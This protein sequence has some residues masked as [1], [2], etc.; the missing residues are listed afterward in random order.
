MCC[1]FVFGGID[2]SEKDGLTIHLSEI[3]EPTLP[4]LVHEILV[5]FYFFSSSSSP[6]TRLERE[7]AAAAGHAALSA[8]HPP[9]EALGQVALRPIA[10]A[11][12]HR[13]LLLPLHSLRADR[14]RHRGRAR[15]PPGV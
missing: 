7:G 8:W 4:F 13:H 1:V 15:R 14:R 9:G 3:E 10:A 6:G 5:L 11:R 12:A 2:S